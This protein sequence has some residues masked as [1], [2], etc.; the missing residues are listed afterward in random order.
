MKR[1]NFKFLRIHSAE[2]IYGI[3][4]STYNKISCSSF[5]EEHWPFDILVTL[6][7]ISTVDVYGV[8]Y[9]KARCS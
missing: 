3:Q 6:D 5:S 2:L 8:K 1:E 4:W 7:V 9:E